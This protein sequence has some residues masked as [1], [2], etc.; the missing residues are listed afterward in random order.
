MKLRKEQINNLFRN[1][2]THCYNC[3]YGETGVFYPHTCRKCDNYRLFDA[4]D[5]FV[6][7]VNEILEEK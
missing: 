5:E 2:K 4:K 1:I 7:N 3:V 6:E